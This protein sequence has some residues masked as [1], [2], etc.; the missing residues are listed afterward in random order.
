MYQW[1]NDNLPNS[2]QI[3]FSEQSVVSTRSTRQSTRQI[4]HIPFTRYNFRL[5]SLKFLVPSIWNQLDTELKV[6][7]SLT[8]NQYCK[9][10]KSRIIK[11]Y[12]Y[13]C[14]INDCYSCHL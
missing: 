5:N 9:T 11:N 1:F 4:M 12:S 13:E 2:I 8:I 10:I 6:N 14:N 7:K 3:L